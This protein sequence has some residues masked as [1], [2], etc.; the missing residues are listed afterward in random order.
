MT[1]PQLRVRS[2][3]TFK[4]VY[5]RT[6]EIIARLKELNCPIAAMVDNNTW[7]HVRWEKACKAADI[8]PIFGMEIQIKVDDERLQGL[9][10]RPKAWIL[11]DDLRKFYNATT[12]AVQNGGL[13]PEEFG[14]LEGVVRFSG[15]ALALLAPDQYDYIDVN[16]SSLL[17]AR[18]GVLAHRETGQPMVITGYNDLPKE[19]Q[20]DFAYAFETR[21]SVGMRTIEDAQDYTS[22]LV[23]IATDEELCDAI[24]VTT[25]LAETL[26]GRA[27]N[28]APIIHLDG[29]MV[30]LAREGMEYRL[31]A[32][33]IKE[34]TPEYEARF[35]EEIKQIQN[36]KF[37]SYFLVVADLVKFAKK[38]M[39]VGPARGS[40]AG[41]L[42]CYCMEITEVDPL[43]H[44]LLFQRF[45]DI[46]RA[47][48]PDIDID[49][50]DT[51]RYM[52]FDYLQEK[53]G[54]ENVVKLGN[55]NTLKANSVM[56][57]VSKRF[58]LPYGAV[59]SVKNA[60]IEYSSGDARYG[61]GLH[62]TMT[63]TTPG[64]L[65]SEQYPEAARCMGDLEIHPSHTGVHA[66][67]I[68][69]CNDP[70][71]DYCTVTAEGIAQIDKPDS[72]YLD[73]LK[74]DALGLR[75]LGI[76]GDTGAVTIE[77]LYSLTLDD[78][79]VLDVLNEDKMSGIFQ[80]E[81]DA[82]R[83]VAR[84]VNIDRFSKI[85]NLTALAR[86]GPLASGMAQKYIA[87]S[88]GD[89][90]VVYDVPQL[91]AYL[92]E[93]FGVFL[94]QEQIMAVVKEIGLFDWVK[95]SAVRK[96][97][98]GRKGEEYFNQQGEDFVRGA[99]ESGV[100]KDQAEKIWR[101]M[102]TFGSW[103]FNK[104]H[105]VSYAIITYWTCYLKRYFPLQFAAACLRAAKDE[106]QTI[107]ILRELAKEGINYTALDPDH[108][109][110]NWTISSDGRLVGG[111]MNAKGYGPAKAAMYVDKRNRGVLTQ[112]DKDRLM[113]AEVLYN[114]LN[115]AHTRFGH[116]YEKPTLIKV[117]RKDSNG[118]PMWDYGKPLMRTKEVLPENMR[119]VKDGEVGLVIGKITKKIVA[120]QNEPIRIK[121][122]LEKGITR[123]DNR[124]GIEVLK[125]NHLPDGRIE[126]PT[127]FI[128]IMCV[129]DSSDSP[130]R[131]RIKEQDYERLG[132]NIAEN[133]PKGSWVMM[134]ALKL[135][136]LDMFF[137][138][139]IRVL[140]HADDRTKED[141]RTDEESSGPETDPEED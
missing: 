76:I 28:K 128:D 34:W 94:Y 47:D 107:A 91:K 80:F 136:G 92:D 108:S 65:F 37:D 129:D 124:R 14:A 39:L 43:P 78:Q 141:V 10:F 75:T 57:V 70:I 9:G 99:V 55:I 45:I 5:G 62:D 123:W 7:G 35:Q 87:R 125:K 25:R 82:V 97:M 95:T 49:F 102:V 114:D 74:I 85:D 46:S 13:T 31:K 16:P 11:A 64:K 119:D 79:S 29:D 77:Q 89:E 50:E 113:K 56:A 44:K 4:E 18:R 27:L 118:K 15:G 98:S 103:G 68:L 24:G 30:A 21:E 104:S 134:N 137:I 130:M 135:S 17:H 52:V 67:G 122:R 132:R 81:G 86:P 84:F 138:N 126:G 105:S 73:L 69:V 8:K 100:P 121:K 61:K 38:H 127:A 117:Q 71:S 36:K 41:S 1:F 33:H 20:K 42:V 111:I 115:E 101:E 19:E 63:T 72:E 110:M 26:A 106:T 83:S 88:K 133:V 59:D 140:S 66:A 54:K 120:D 58:R 131:F 53:Y 90:E 112:A 40:S 6:G 60:L 12:K 116:L 3:Y 22:A 48:L 109:E 51:K 32:G 139:N 96:A 2:A 93:T 23:G